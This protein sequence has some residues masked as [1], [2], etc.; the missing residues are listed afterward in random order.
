MTKNLTE[1]KPLKLIFHFTVPIL[2]GMLFQQIYSMADAAIVGKYLGKEALAAVGSTSS[3]NFLL[4]GFVTGV[5]SGFAVPIA[6][7]FGAKDE[8]GLRKTVANSA[9][10]SVIISIL[11]ALLTTLLCRWILETMQTPE[12]IIDG[13]YKYIVIILAGIPATFLYNMTAGIIRSIGDS[14]TPVYFLLMSAM[15]NILLDVYFIVCLGMHVEGAAIATVISQLV[16][17]LACL[18]YMIKKYEILHIRQEEWKIDSQIVR[19]LCSIGIP[20]GLQYSVTAIGNVILQSALNKLGS[21]PVAAFTAGSKL[22][23]LLICPFEAIGTAMATYAGQN[24]GARK[25]ERIAPGV[26]S[27]FGI[28]MVFAVLS[29]VLIWFWGPSLLLLF[30]SAEDSLLIADAQKYILYNVLAFMLLN[31]VCVFRF[32][33][34]G[35][36]YGSFAIW[37]GVFEMAA[38]ILGAWVLVPWIGYTGVCLGTPLA[39]LF[40]TAFLLPAYLYCRRKIDREISADNI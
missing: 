7:R 8:E 21:D 10:L 38:R 12:N 37:A 32:T 28:G 30:L 16:S 26:K 1:G 2:L 17:G 3:V 23:F 19:N 36:G 40:A 18:V 34:Q 29:F 27:A 9:L 22:F 6:H 25:I 5:C 31:A 15:L 33:I 11:L 13:A 14:K 20:M 4:L 35:M 39:W 24:I